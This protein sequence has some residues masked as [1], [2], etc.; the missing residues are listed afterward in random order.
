MPER[1]VS[2]AETLER[3]TTGAYRLQRAVRSLSQEELDLSERPGQ[4]TIR[5]INLQLA[6]DGGAWAL[7]TKKAI[8]AIGALVR[9]EGF[10]GNEAW[11]LAL[12]FDR[13]PVRPAVALIEAHRRVLAE[14]VGAIA[15][16]WKR[17]VTVFDAAG[18]EVQTLTCREI[19]GK[20]A[21]HLCRHVDT[22][23]KIRRTHNL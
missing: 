3:F 5:Q 16:A 11:V 23:W 4:W 7:P 21:D 13:R 14:M 20:L 6:D 15:G 18:R 9:F 10:P 12:A 17:H 8:A 2:R 19:I 1:T 22:I